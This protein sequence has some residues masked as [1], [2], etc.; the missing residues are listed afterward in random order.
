MTRILSTTVEC[1]SDRYSNNELH[2]LAVEML[3]ELPEAVGMSAWVD[4]GCQNHE[5]ADA[6]VRKSLM[7][8][9]AVLAK[10]VGGWDS[11][12]EMLNAEAVGQMRNADEALGPGMCG[13]REDDQ[14]EDL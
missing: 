12:E 10:E 9:L 5:A 7:A 6:C 2:A 14:E 1:L 3:G 11:V 8:V 4:E 13:G